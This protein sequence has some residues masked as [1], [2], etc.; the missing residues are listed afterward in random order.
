MVFE[1]SPAIEV[2][3]QDNGSGV[4][5]DARRYVFDAFFTTKTKGTGLGM[6]IARRIIEA[7]GGRLELGDSEG[8]AEFVIQ[9]PRG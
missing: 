5:A 2:A 3:I 7:H 9:L 6:A 8:G 1:E 4:A